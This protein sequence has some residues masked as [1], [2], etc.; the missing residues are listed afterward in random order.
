MIIEP[1]RTADI[2]HFLA[3]A[4]TENWV[5]ESWEFEFLL[6]TFAQGCFVAREDSGESI[7]FVTSMRHERSGWI[8]N[9][10]VKSEYRGIGIGDKLFIRALEAL[11][12]SGV[13]TFWLTASKSGRSLYE[14]YGFSDIDNIIRWVGSGRQRTGDNRGA[15]GHEMVAESSHKLDTQA[16]GDRREILFCKTAHRGVILQNESGFLVLQP[17]GNAVQFGS[18]S[19][20]NDG[21]AENLFDEAAKTIAFGTR[22]L[23]DAPVSNQ[24]A[25]RLFNRKKMRIAGSNS[26]MYAG[27][28]PGFR[29]DLI[30]GLATM[31]SCG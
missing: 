2:A 9:L 21:T 4:T 19:A 20:L 5:A 16:W 23:L 26:L 6:S 27:I 13:E 1:F 22:F 30:F 15:V 11:R 17:C 18:F 25:L 29:P 3:L 8:G 7:G 24:T 31:G 14:K 28:K 12:L 10:I